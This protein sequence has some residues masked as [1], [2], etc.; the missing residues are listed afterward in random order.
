MAHEKEDTS[1]PGDPQPSMPQLSEA[2]LQAI[3]EGVVAKLQHQ[4][5]GK[6]KGKGKG[7]ASPMPGE[8]SEANGKSFRPSSSTPAGV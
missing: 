5:A 8:T 3:I 7:K 6:G 2:Y 1:L 4:P